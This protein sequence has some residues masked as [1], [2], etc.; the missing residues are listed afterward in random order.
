MEFLSTD[1]DLAPMPNSDPSVNLV[2]AGHKTAAES[3]SLTKRRALFRIVRVR[4]ASEWLVLYFR[5]AQWLLK[6]CETILIAR[7]R[8]KYSF[9]NRLR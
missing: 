8:S 6:R 9:P 1:T 5:Y 4:I 3:I 7:M 2:E